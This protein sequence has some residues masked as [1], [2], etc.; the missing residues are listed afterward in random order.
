MYLLGIQKI[1]CY[2]LVA[3]AALIVEANSMLWAGFTAD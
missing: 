1:I 3:Y 2:I